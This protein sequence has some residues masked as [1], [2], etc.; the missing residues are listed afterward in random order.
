MLAAD[1][2]GDGNLDL[3]FNMGTGFL[4]LLNNGD[5]TFTN[6]PTFAT[7]I[8]F[9]S[10][11]AD[12]NG[13]GKMDIVAIPT[14]NA[15]SFSVWLGN[16]DGT[17]QSPHLVPAGLNITNLVVADFSGD[18]KPD[19]IAINASNPTTPMSRDPK[20]AGNDTFAAPVIFAIGTDTN[21]LV[22][23]D[24]NGDGKADILTR[25]TTS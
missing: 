22:A 7:P 11:A 16:G 13:D 14:P 6:Q 21:H 1:F 8:S 9:R 4:V 2:N 15:T 20:H 23:A 19:V 3:W 24:F 17:F 12:I 10:A 18:G 5:G 25:T